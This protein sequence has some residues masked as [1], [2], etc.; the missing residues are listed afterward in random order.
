MSSNANR[1]CSTAARPCTRSDGTPPHRCRQNAS[2]MLPMIP[3][4]PL[5]RRHEPG[6]VRLRQRPDIPTSG[7]P[8][9]KINAVPYPQRWPPSPR[10][11]I[12][13]RRV[14]TARPDFVLPHLRCSNAPSCV[15]AMRQQLR[16]V[17]APA[18]RPAVMFARMSGF[19][20]V[21]G[22]TALH[23]FPGLPS[24][25]AGRRLTRHHAPLA[26]LAEQQTLN[27]RV[28]GSSP[29]RRTYPELVFLLSLY[30]GRRPFP[31]HGCST[32]ARQSEH[33]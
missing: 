23:R 22:G 20:Q 17:P 30:P 9:R 21:A 32:F 3:P 24:G 33:S 15:H 13:P 28:R 14:V 12:L 26:Q 16:T 7:T 2:A 31:G 18:D 29:W 19:A 5:P 8:R 10:G 27:L 4:R 11:S 25:P 6:P 1:V